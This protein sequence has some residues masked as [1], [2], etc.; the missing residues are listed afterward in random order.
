MEI[1]PDYIEHPELIAATSTNGHVRM[2]FVAMDQNGDKVNGIPQA[3][4][5]I[6]NATLGVGSGNNVTLL[7]HLGVQRPP[8]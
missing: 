8:E 1:L 3:G 2:L 7:T 5:R 4:M 6:V